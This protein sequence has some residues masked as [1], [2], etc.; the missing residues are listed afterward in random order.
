M[1][2]IGLSFT[3]EFETYKQLRERMTS[4]SES[5]RSSGVKAEAVRV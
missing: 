5:L 3:F 4:R 1:I 2:N